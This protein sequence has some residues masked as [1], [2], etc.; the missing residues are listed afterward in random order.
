MEE[1]R[2]DDRDGPG[3]AAHRVPL[4][5]HLAAR[6]AHSRPGRGNPARHRTLAPAGHGH[7]PVLRLGR[8]LLRAAA[9]AR[10]AAQGQQAARAR[11]LAPRRDRD[12]QHRLPHPP[13]IGYPDAGPAL[14]RAPG[15][16]DVQPRPPSGINEQCAIPVTTRAPIT[17]ISWRY[18]RAGWTT[19][20]TATS[21]T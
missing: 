9:G 3:A 11:G 1:D 8:D 16:P 13:R 7:A 6:P 15:H 5:L 19:T 4:A 17:G 18:P 21:T 2:A 12:R 10:R 14:G 20:R